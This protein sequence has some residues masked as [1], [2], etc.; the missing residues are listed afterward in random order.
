VLV[1]TSAEKATIR[2][3]GTK[4]SIIHQKEEE[5]LAAKERNGKLKLQQLQQ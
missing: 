3:Y 4:P 2:E 1:R 5:T